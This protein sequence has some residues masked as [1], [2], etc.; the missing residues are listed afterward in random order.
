MRECEEMWFERNKRGSK[1]LCRENCTR[2][3]ILK[4]NSGHIMTGNM[5]VWLDG[6]GKVFADLTIYTLAGYLPN[7]LN[8]IF[9]V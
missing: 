8:I 7:A 4:I 2:W 5:C 6:D 3:Q 9:T 1:P